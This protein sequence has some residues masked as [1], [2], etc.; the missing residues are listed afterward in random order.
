MSYS[1]GET[2]RSGPYVGT[3]QMGDN[4][5]ASNRAAGLEHLLARLQTRIDQLVMRALTQPGYDDEIAGL[6]SV[7]DDLLERQRRAG[8]HPAQPRSG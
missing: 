2:R 4:E 7:R 1:D 6:V 8:R 5:S 3:T